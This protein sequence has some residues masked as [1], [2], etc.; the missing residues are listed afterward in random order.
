[1]PGSYFADLAALPWRLRFAARKKPLR[2]NGGAFRG[3]PP[4]AYQDRA[5]PKIFGLIENRDRGGHFLPHD[6]AETE[7]PPRDMFEI[8][9]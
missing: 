3:F 5:I 4:A 8:R 6:A 2:E 7:R 9:L 1:M